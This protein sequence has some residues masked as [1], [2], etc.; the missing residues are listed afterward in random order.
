MS[1]VAEARQH[2]AEIHHRLRNPQNAVEDEGI[3]LKRKPK[4]VIPVA[5]LSPEPA[6]VV[7]ADR[8]PTVDQVVRSIE[9]L[10]AQLDRLY[11]E[12]ARLTGRSRPSVR[13]IQK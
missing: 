9:K 13:A 7:V 6:P 5:D 12:H 1:A 2:A 11:D 10:N 3:D 8:G 4:V